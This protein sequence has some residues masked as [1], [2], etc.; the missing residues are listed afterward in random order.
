LD[1][2]RAVASG[3]HLANQQHTELDELVNVGCL[4]MIDGLKRFDPDRGLRVSTY[5]LWWV[6]NAIHVHVRAVR[7]QSQVSETDYKVLMKLHKAL[8]KM[9]TRFDGYIDFRQLAALLK[10]NETECQR[11]FALS[12]A[13][14]SI[15]TP[16]SKNG[17]LKL[18]DILTNPEANPSL[19]AARAS[20]V[21]LVQEA[22]S[23]LPSQEQIALDEFFFQEREYIKGGDRDEKKKKRD[24]KTYRR[25]KAISLL[26]KS[27]TIVKAYNTLQI[28]SVK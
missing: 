6:R 10:M 11:L 4:G 19:A 18:G 27:P 23:H 21:S 17:K 26:K 3:I 20:V 25:Q 12:R 1:M 14:R 9:P 22:V 7:W 5:C 8:A 15:E 24:A 28:A 2:I 16:I 13:I